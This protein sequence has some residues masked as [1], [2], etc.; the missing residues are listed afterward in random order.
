MSTLGVLEVTGS[1]S[2]TRES[3]LEEIESTTGEKKARMLPMHF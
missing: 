2:M 3:M 1:K